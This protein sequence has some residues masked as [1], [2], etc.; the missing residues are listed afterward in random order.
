MKRIAV[1]GMGIVSPLGVG[2][3]HVWE[4]LVRGDSG[5]TAIDRFPVDQF[6]AKI[7]GVV[8]HGSN[9]GELDF[10]G[11]FS[12]ADQKKN[13]H[14]ILYALAASDEALKHAGWI[15][16]SDKDCERTGVLLGS[17][18]GGLPYIYNNSVALFD[19][20]FRRVS[21]Y[22]IPSC[23]INLAPGQISIRH[24][25]KGPN[26]SVVT[27]CAA[28]SHAIGE[29]A[30]IIREGDADVMLVG[31]TEAAVC[32]LGVAGFAS[33]KALSTRSNSIPSEASRPFD[34]DRDGFV[35]GEG[36]GLLVLENWDHA[37]QRGAVI[38][39]EVVGY[40]LSGDAYH[41]AAPDGRGALRAMKQALKMAKIAPDDIGYINA[42]G[43]ST[44]QGDVA[45]VNAIHEV[46]GIA[47]KDLMVSSTKSAIG[48]LL[49]GAGGVEAL[50]SIQALKTG[51][52]PP[53]LNMHESDIETDLD[54]VPLK[55]KEK[56]MNYVLSN[57]FGFGGTNAAVIFKKV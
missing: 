51:V 29:G 47:S 48:H 33:I 44:P 34:K 30:R 20:G 36:A 2:L 17:G 12:F 26:L 7:A 45:E 18:I 49:G 11:L 5:I 40:G 9:T 3:T 1:T 22:F 10:D 54:F 24:Q 16:Q 35:M 41:V 50:F 4:R 53:T 23:L 42:H 57:S 6:P 32:P 31:G 56:K 27:A 13:D 37:V 21:P 8:P 52:V 43:T 39:A 38:H 15:P 25:L 19:K 28:G 14:F 55:A 46:F